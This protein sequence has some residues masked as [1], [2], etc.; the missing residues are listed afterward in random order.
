VVFLGA[1]DVDIPPEVRPW[2]SPGPERERRE[3]HAE[4]LVGDSIAAVTY[5]GTPSWPWRFR[6]YD[7]VSHG[8]ELATRGGHTFSSTWAI[9][10][11]HVGLSFRREAMR[12]RWMSSYTHLRVWEPEPGGW[13]ALLT[14]RIDEVV[15][16]WWACG[17]H[18]ATLRAGE[19]TVHLV[20]GGAGPDDGLEGQDENVAVVF[21]EAVAERARLGPW[22]PGG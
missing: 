8:V 7:S 13:A 18:A 9:D 21:D 1:A 11:A 6:G 16:H 5:F 4:L 17:C 19:H 2:A 20:L 10:R 12:P 15:L 14:R 22:M 3:R